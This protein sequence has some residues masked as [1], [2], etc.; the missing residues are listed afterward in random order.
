MIKA[1]EGTYNG[2]IYTTSAYSLKQAELQLNIKLKER[3]GH[4]GIKD[5]REK[6][7][8]STQTIEKLNHSTYKCS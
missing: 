5:I 6:I 7:I 4:T 1:F 2:E 8:Y 3:T